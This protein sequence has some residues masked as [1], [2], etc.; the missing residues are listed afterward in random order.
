MSDKVNA[1]IVTLDK[2]YREDDIQDLTMAISL[3]CGVVKVSLNVSDINSHVA[4][5]RVKVKI[6][7]KLIEIMGEFD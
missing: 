4:R 3:F 2:D 5:E 1:I 6:R 7:G